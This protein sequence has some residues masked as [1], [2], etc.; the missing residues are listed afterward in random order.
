MYE[1]YRCIISLNV[2]DDVIYI[3]KIILKIFAERIEVTSYTIYLFIGRSHY[4]S[5]DLF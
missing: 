2:N 4:K 3:T 1:V 5:N